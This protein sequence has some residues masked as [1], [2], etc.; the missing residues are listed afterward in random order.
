MVLM[1][2][3]SQS[4]SEEEQQGEILAF[5]GEE[6]A[7][8]Y[9]ESPDLVPV[10]PDAETLSKAMPQNQKQDKIINLAIKAEKQPVTDNI[11]TTSVEVKVEPEG[12]KVPPL[13][14]N[15]GK[16]AVVFYNN[17]LNFTITK[18]LLFIN[19]LF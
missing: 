4:V 6:E 15:M 13:A 9:R 16:F 7:D 3:V 1:K 17:I 11:P 18:G 8:S 19:V 10:Q 12:E 14:E 5:Y 2:I